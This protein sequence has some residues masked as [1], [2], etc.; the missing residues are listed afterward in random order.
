MDSIVIS[1]VDRHTSGRV[2][3]CGCARR[4]CVRFY[5]LR[6]CRPS[7]APVG[8]V[9]VLVERVRGAWARGRSAGARRLRPGAPS[10]SS[11]DVILIL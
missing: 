8:R 5:V 3:T 1:V 9:G 11:G 4:A 6:H 2:R 7:L 10:L